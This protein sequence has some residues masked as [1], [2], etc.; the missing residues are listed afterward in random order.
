MFELCCRKIL[1]RRKCDNVRGL[2]GWVL[3]GN[4]GRNLMHVM[5]RRHLCCIY[6]I[7]NFYRLQQLRRRHLLGGIGVDSLRKMPGWKV[8]IDYWVKHI[9]GLRKLRRRDVHDFYG[10]PMHA[11]CD[12]HLY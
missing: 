8:N 2:C 1:D 11:M 5:R 7:V 9:F 12:W 10:S 6:R 4:I 3:R